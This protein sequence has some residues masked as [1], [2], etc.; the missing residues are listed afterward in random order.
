MATVQVGDPVIFCDTG[1]RLR[2]KEVSLLGGL[3]VFV[4]VGEGSEDVRSYLDHDLAR[5]SEKGS[6]SSPA[7]ANV[8]SDGN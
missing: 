3:H 1:E 7:H 6:W 5:P 2:L 8:K 4:C